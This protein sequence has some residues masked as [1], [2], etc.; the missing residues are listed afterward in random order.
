M[1]SGSAA[2]ARSSKSRLTARPIASGV[3]SRLRRLRRPSEASIALS[4]SRQTWAGRSRSIT[5]RQSALRAR[6]PAA[7][8]D[9]NRGPTPLPRVGRWRDRPARSPTVRDASRWAPPSRSPYSYRTLRPYATSLPPRER[10]SR[11]SRGAFR[12][13]RDSGARPLP[14]RWR[15]GRSATTASARAPGTPPALAT[16]RTRDNSLPTRTKAPAPPARDH[17]SA[18]REARPFELPRATRAFRDG[19][20]PDRAPPRAARQARASHRWRR[21][22]APPVPSGAGHAGAPRSVSGGAGE[23]ELGARLRG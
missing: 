10:D 1:G 23:R 5:P 18:A 9:D 14:S 20:H 22:R 6:T 7:R 19:S 17:R 12:R 4:S 13:R 21:G 8:V 11:G 3:V 16:P 2:I 15:S